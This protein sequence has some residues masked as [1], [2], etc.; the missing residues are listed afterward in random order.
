MSKKAIIQNIEI[1]VISCAVVIMG[2]VAP[3]VLSA[4]FTT[5]LR[6]CTGWATFS[7]LGAGL[8]SYIILSTERLLYRSLTIGA[9]SILSA[10][11]F[12]YLVFGLE[13]YRFASSALIFDAGTVL[14]PLNIGV[15]LWTS[16]NAKKNT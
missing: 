13:A 10:A 6:G 15:R 7:L 14:V 2:V 9:L 16:L 1:M 5:V 12:L 11:Y 8:V 4:H 3:F